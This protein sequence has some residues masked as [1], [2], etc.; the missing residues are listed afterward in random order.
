MIL[1]TTIYLPWDY[2]YGKRPCTNPHQYQYPLPSSPD[3]HLPSN[4]DPLIPRHTLTQPL[5]NLIDSSPVRRSRELNRVGMHDPPRGLEDTLRCDGATIDSF[6]R[7]RC[8]Q[9]DIESIQ[10]ASG[11]ESR[12]GRETDR[13]RSRSRGTRSIE[14]DSFECIV[15]FNRMS[16]K[17]VMTHASMTPQNVFAESPSSV[18]PI[19]LRPHLHQHQSRR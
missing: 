9:L 3:L 6:S 14:P 12:E 16:G 1:S 4:K 15:H 11:G 2:E 8:S 18:N 10:V 17:S 13:T 19:C 5:S 7:L